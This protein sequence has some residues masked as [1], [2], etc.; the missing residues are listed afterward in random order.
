LYEVNKW[1]VWGRLS[2][3]YDL[4]NQR[5]SCLYFTQI[6]GQYRKT[7]HQK[8]LLMV[9]KPCWNGLYI[10]GV[11]GFC[12]ISLLSWDIL[13]CYIRNWVYL[14][15]LDGWAHLGNDMALVLWEEK[16]SAMKIVVF[17]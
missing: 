8:R 15:I 3:G 2:T 13:N 9:T 11:N 16:A 17:W 14:L 12:W 1:G 10:V 4:G 6:N 5:N 7:L